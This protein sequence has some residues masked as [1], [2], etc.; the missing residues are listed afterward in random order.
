MSFINR[1]P[2]FL[3]IVIALLITFSCRNNDTPKDVLDA[4]KLENILYDY[5]LAQSLALQ[6][7]ADSV[8]YYTRLYQAAVFKKYGITQAQFDHSMQWYESHTER[9]KKIYDHLTTRLGGGD[10]KVSSS[11][12]PKPLAQSNTLV[13]NDTLNIWHGPSSVLLNSQSVNRFKYSQRADTTIQ[14]GDELQLNFNVDW[15]YHDGERRVVAY[16]VIHY[17]GDSTAIMQKFVYASGLQQANITIGQRKVKNI[18]CFIYQCST[19]ADRVRIASITN[20]RLL[21]LRSKNKTNEHDNSINTDSTERN[22]RLKN[23]Q[24]RLRDSLIKE[25]KNNETKPHFI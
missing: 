4:N 23:P 8:N 14:A 5:H 24:L 25:E 11:V 12:S 17:E 16:V 1:I 19:W 9:L 13:S 7:N 18:D 6:A 10:N 21:R 20:I 3:V 2:S 15:F 22:L